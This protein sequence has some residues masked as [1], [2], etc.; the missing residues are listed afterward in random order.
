[1]ISWYGDEE[2]QSTRSRR[3][4]NKRWL[5]GL[6]LL[7]R[8]LWFIIVLAFN[9]TGTLSLFNDFIKILWLS[10]RW[11]ISSM[12]FKW[13]NIIAPCNVVCIL[14]FSTVQWPPRNLYC[15]YEVFVIAHRAL[16]SLLARGFYT[17]CGTRS[18]PLDSCRTPWLPYRD[19]LVSHT[20]ECLLFFHLHKTWQHTLGSHCCLLLSR[21]GTTPRQN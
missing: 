18:Y 4:Q 6:N 9:I 3:F 10:Q 11:W 7:Q 8:S 16:N 13:S 15:R 14:S 12:Y 21:T 1:M 2:W 17:F 20:L 19:T 5:I